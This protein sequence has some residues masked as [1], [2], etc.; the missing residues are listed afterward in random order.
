[1]MFDCNAEQENRFI[2]EISKKT[3]EELRDRL[4]I[5]TEELVQSR[6]KLD[7]ATREL[8]T[9]EVKIEEL[10]AE[11]QDLNQALVSLSKNMQRTIEDL[12]LE[13][14]TAIRMKIL[15]ILERL[16]DRSGIG[17]HLIEF[18]MLSLYMNDMVSKLVGGNSVIC[19][20]STAELRVAA[21]V[22]NRLTNDQI[23]DQLCLSMATVKTHRRNIRKKLRIENPQMNLSMYLKEQW[24]KAIRGETVL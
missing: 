9:R 22:K 24:G 17:Q 18:D 15:P 12:E 13:A 23:A 1:M 4:N 21:L 8:R 16:Q 3:I 20:L 6:A 10:R 7:N 14:A 2:I 5:R 11:L 19:A